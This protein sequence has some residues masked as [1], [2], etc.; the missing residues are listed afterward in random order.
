MNKPRQYGTPKE[1]ATRLVAALGLERAASHSRVSKSTL[2]RYTDPQHDDQMPIDIA[3]T[4]EAVARVCPVTEFLAANAGMALLPLDVGPDA[5]PIARDMAKIG[6]EIAE[7]FQSYAAAIADGGI[8]RDEARAML[9]ECDDS[10]RALAA[11]RSHCQA[12][13]EG[14]EDR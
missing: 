9:R 6:G 1:A 5:I 7:L 3:A 12:I 2:F 11:L 13:A 8:E 4:L 14:E 10:L